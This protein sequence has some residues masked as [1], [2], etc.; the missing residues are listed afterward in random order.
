METLNLGTVEL[1]PLPNDQAT[2]SPSQ[3][4][5]DGGQKAN[6]G[7]AN[8]NPAWPPEALAQAAIGLVDLVCT[9]AYNSPLNDFEKAALTGSFVPLAQKYCNTS[10]IAP[11]WVALGTLAIVF[12]PRHFARRELTE[13]ESHNDSSS[14]RQEGERQKPV[15]ASDYM[16]ETSEAS[17]VLGFGT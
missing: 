7:Q 5:T 8:A 3:T 6:S 17:K 14:A 11:E 2:P 12:V 4:T 15:S 9:K 13:G 10:D 1:P 16:G